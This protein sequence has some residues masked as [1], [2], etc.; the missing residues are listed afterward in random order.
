MMEEDGDE[1]TQKQH[2]DM[3]EWKA[4]AHGRQVA[5]GREGDRAHRERP[6]GSE[7]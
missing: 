7:D 2:M 3:P 5:K 1:R 6:S 4:W